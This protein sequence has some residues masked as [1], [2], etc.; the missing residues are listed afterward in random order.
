MAGQTVVVSVLAD[1]KKFSSAMKKLGDETGMSKLASGAKKV[2]G[3]FKTAGKTIGAAGLAITALAI[4]GGIDR[5]LQIENAEAKLKGL[6]YATQDITKIM[7]N[8]LAAVKGTSFG[9]GEAATTAATAMAAGVAQGKDLESYLRLVGD[10]ATIAGADMGEMGSI[11]NKVQASGKMMTDNLNQLQDRGIP[12]LQWL[13]E[14][15]GVT[16]GEMSKMV[17]QGKVD[18]ETFRKVMQDNLGGAALESGNTTQGAFKN[19]MAALSRA[20]LALVNDVFPMF[21]DA[22]SGIGKF[23][24]GVPEKVAPI[25]KAVSQ[26][27]TNTAVPAFQKLGDWFNDNRPTIEAFA[28]KVKD[29]AERGFAIAIKVGAQVIETLRNIATWVKENQAW[30]GPLASAIAAMVAAYMAVQKVIAI[31]AALKVA[32]AAARVAAIAFNT[33]LLAN[34]IGL[35]IAGVAALVA[36]LTYF[37]T[38]TETGKELWDKVWNGIKA[39][40]E[41]VSGAIMA[42]FDAFMGYITP[43]FETMGAAW[44]IVWDGM[45]AVAQSVSDWF[46]THVGPVFAAFG[47]LVSAVWDTI[48]E[49]LELAWTGI[50]LVWDLMSASWELVWGLIM[51]VWESVGPPLIAAMQAAWENAKVVM[52]TVWNVIKTVFGAVWNQIKTIFETVWNIIKTVIETAMGVIKGIITTVTGLIKGDWSQ[53]WEGIK[54]VASSVW[55]GIKS[56]VSTGI[57]YVKSTISNVLNAVKGVWESVWN[58]IKSFASTVWE[59]IKSTFSAGVGTMRDIFT[60]MGDA[61]SSPFKSAFNGIARA[62]NNTV[63]KLSFEVP[64][65]V[66]GMGGK[67]WSAPT[68]P[69]L[70]K[71]GTAL[72]AGWSLIGEEG[73]ELLHMPRGASVV[74]LDHPM[75]A[76][77]ITN[78]SA[79]QPAAYGAVSN[80]RKVEDLLMQL[81]TAVK[82]TASPGPGVV[83]NQTNNNPQAIPVVTQTQ[84][85]LQ[86]LAALGYAGTV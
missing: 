83:I 24:D 63:G 45:K 3:A 49:R 29:L 10:A 76:N 6:G 85:A 51:A 75:S 32:M 15:Y 34:P 13:A 56:L 21:K 41:T 26:W 17:T 74:P 12:V 82:E 35:I 52:E 72:A 48:R 79:V 64:N 23:L 5:A 69:M 50:Q 68:L 44:G 54:Q 55:T 66:P 42:G 37:F 36:G 67:G 65:W 30:L 43:I 33:A 80:S 2:G 40:W 61:I 70:A 20:G 1:T 62:W 60:R 57:N 14:E 58:G 46:S 39:T 4:K 53:V 81:I 22:F 84:S 71:G 86:T 59:G 25:G 77:A 11:F 31:I 73:P 16:A 19:M 27:I 28:N 9:M 8:A 78:P 18:S 47:E 7:D 38:Q